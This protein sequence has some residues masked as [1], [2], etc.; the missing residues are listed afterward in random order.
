MTDTANREESTHEYRHIEYRHSAS[1]SSGK[2]GVGV[3]TRR[4]KDR[5]APVARRLS[6]GP[7]M[8][9]SSLGRWHGYLR[10]A[11]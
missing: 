3:I 11:A 9:S 5:R 4:A 10:L 6:Q 8:C 2:R 1:Q 7:A